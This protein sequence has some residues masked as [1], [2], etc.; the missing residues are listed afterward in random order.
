M[1]IQAYTAAD[2]EACL[3]IFDS[4]APEFLPTEMREDLAAFLDTH[5]GTFFVAEHDGAIVGCGGYTLAAGSA[6]L[7]WGMVRRPWQRQGLGR[8]LLFYRMREIGK[9][10]AVEHV[11]LSTPPA[12]AAFF[13]TQGFREA[14]SDGAWLVM[15][16]RLAVCA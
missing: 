8:F 16:K 1:E 5:A 2:R 6:S 4:N 14:G 7:H 3:E 10:G 12:A 15:V 13:A 11:K 9:A